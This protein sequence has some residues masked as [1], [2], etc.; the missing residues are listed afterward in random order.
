MADPKL[1]ALAKGR[2]GWVVLWEREVNGQTERC[3]FGPFEQMQAAAD[4]AHVACIM[5]EELWAVVPLWDYR[6]VG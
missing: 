3:A 1:E 4:Y 5:E 6:E 2:T